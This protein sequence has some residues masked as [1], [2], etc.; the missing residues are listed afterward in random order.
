MS[1][2]RLARV[3]AWAAA[4]TPASLPADVRRRAARLQVSTAAAVRAADLDV[5]ATLLDG[6]AGRDGL[7]S[8]VERATARDY[9]DFGLW[10][11]PAP[12][13]IG[14]WAAGVDTERTLAATAVGL[15]VVARLGTWTM[16]S[17]TPAHARAWLTA[18]GVAVALAH[19]RGLP[20]DGIANALALALANP[21]EL[22]PHELRS[23]GARTRRHGDAAGIGF[24]AVVRA[25][26]GERGDPAVLDGVDGLLG[27]LP[28]PAPL[29]HVFEDLGG[30]WHS[31]GL[32]HR[33]QPVAPWLQTPVQAFHEILRRHQKAASK[34][35]RADQIDRIEV[36]VDHLAW[37]RA[38]EDA[39]VDGMP[40]DGH[41]SYAL[42]IVIGALVAGHE[43]GPALYDHA[44]LVPNHDAILEVAAKVD[45]RPDL[46]HTL[47]RVR[48][49]ARA[50]G[51]LLVDVPF[52]TRLSLAAGLVGKALRGLP[53]PDRLDLRGVYRDDPVDA[54]RGLIDP[55][56]EPPDGPVHVPNATFVRLYTSRGGWWPERR[57]VIEGGPE[58]SAA[59]LDRDVVAKF[60]RCVAWKAGAVDATALQGAVTAARRFLDAPPATGALAL[61]G[62]A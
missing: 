5:G 54:L 53:N 14:A 2:P 50:L 45:L 59:D 31:R 35:L 26:D 10:G 8:T 23:V 17:P 11:H 60:G 61:L 13:A 12:A 58:Y 33:L 55:P 7:V 62:A 30:T 34:R 21:I 18:A 16:L 42:P 48:G 46:G 24:D 27:A 20:A 4:V 41:L 57:D 28:T 22:E 52:A 47:R 15:E 51:P 38:R 37:M 56:G 43:H 40:D 32:V 44:L 1:E 19:A 36:R 3:A 49:L 9:D 6:R 25:H 39:R 29:G